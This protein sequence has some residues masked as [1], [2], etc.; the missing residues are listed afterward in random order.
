MT[1]ARKTLKLWA[2]QISDGS[3]LRIYGNVFDCY[4]GPVHVAAT[5]FFSR[6]RAER[7]RQV[8]LLHSPDSRAKIVRFREEG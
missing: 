3:Y 2:I 4:C 8:E 7:V 5:L 1:G 6:K